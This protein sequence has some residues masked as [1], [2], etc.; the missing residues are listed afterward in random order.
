[1]INEYIKL[2]KSGFLE[3]IEEITIEF[4]LCKMETMKIFFIINCI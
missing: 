1:M 2:H 3:L 4:G